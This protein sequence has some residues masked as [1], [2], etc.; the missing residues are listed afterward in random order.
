MAAT[1]TREEV[2]AVLATF[3]RRL[4]DKVGPSNSTSVALIDEA[5][6]DALGAL[7]EQLERKTGHMTQAA[8][9][10]ARRPVAQAAQEL[11]A[12]EWLP[13]IFADRHFREAIEACDKLLTVK[14]HDYTQGHSMKDNDR[15]RLA[16]FYKNADRLGLSPFKVLSIYM[17]KHVDAVETYLKKGEVKSEPIEGRVFDVVNYFLLLYKLIQ[18]EQQQPTTGRSTTRE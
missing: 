4:K 9:E 2:Q 14:G 10:A 8:V 1:W 11:S 7:G 12:K 6:S 5:Y 3:S 15:G 13:H 18:V 16:N 17:F